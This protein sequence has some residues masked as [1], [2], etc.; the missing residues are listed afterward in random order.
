MFCIYYSASYV[1][2]KKKGVLLMLGWFQRQVVVPAPEVPPPAPRALRP[3]QA[4]GGR[5][6]ACP[7]RAVVPTLEPSRALRPH[8]S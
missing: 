3:A 7:E 8:W 2:A 6:T 5:A 4:A 1:L